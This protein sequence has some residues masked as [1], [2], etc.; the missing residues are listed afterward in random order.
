MMTGHGIRGGMTSDEDEDEGEVVSR[1]RTRGMRTRMW[2]GG[3]K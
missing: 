2:E 3:V 1:T